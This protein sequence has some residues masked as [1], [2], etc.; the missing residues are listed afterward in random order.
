MCKIN[1]KALLKFLPFW[2]FEGLFCV[3][4]NVSNKRKIV[5]NKQRNHC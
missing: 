2:V 5:N 1:Q 4:G 3:E